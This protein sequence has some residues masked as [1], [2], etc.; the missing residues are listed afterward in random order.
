MTDNIPRVLPEGRRAV[1]NTGSWK[2]NP[3]FALIAEGGGI[4]GPEMMRT[5]NAGIGYVL[6]VRKKDAG[7]ILKAL[8]AM[9]ERGWDIG[10]IRESGKGTAP[11]V[12]YI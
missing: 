6:I 12:E 7:P 11:V 10:E 8:K 4:S 9:G 5:F 3:I 2:P 1:I